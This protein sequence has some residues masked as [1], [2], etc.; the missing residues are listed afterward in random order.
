LEQ[1]ISE[2]YELIVCAPDE[3]TL[4]V[5]RM[6]QR[7]N[8]FIV[9]LKDPG[10]GKP[11]A[12]NY[13]V[14]TARGTILV[15]SDGD[16]RIGKNSLGKMISLFK[17][18]EVGAVTG[19]V[20]AANSRTTLWGFWAHMLT[21]GFHLSRMRAESKKT[22]SALYRLSLCCAKELDSSPSS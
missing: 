3:E 8:K 4:N 11:T 13:C 15:L 16:V 18:K 6:Y 2:P 14:Q 19:R 9:V 22:F 12:L 17:R 1:D 20:Y 10:K 5:A 21:E 7:R